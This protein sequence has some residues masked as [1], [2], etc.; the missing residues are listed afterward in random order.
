MLLVGGQTLGDRVRAAYLLQARRDP[1]VV[2]AGV[3]ATLAADELK[4]AAFHLAVHHPDRLAAQD[5]GAAM[6]RLASLR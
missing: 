3:V 1:R 4:R 6:T 2:Q 5:R